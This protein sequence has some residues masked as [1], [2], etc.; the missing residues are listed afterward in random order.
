MIRKPVEA[1]LFDC[2]GTL[3]DD[4]EVH[5]KLWPIVFKEFGLGRFDTKAG[6]SVGRFLKHSDLSNVEIRKF[7]KRFNGM[8]F[9]L[10]P[11]IFSGANELLRILKKKGVLIAIVTNR[12][13]A[14]NYLRFLI[15]AGLDINL[16]DYFVNHDIVPPLIKLLPNQFSAVSNKPKPEILKQIIKILK[17][18]SGFPKSVL[19]VGDSWADL[20]LARNCGFQFAGVLSGPVR[21]VKKW[22]EFGIRDQD[23]VFKEVSGLIKVF[24]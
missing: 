21:S 13:T 23:V 24:Q 19:M 10:K 14:H 3:V 5:H 18:L 20:H 9:D 15:Q 8:E 16:V 11:R 12:P 22:K 17:K 7:W 6:K 1:V 2:D 4:L